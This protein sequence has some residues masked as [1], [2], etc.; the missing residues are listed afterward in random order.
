VAVEAWRSAC[1]SL[2]LTVMTAPHRLVH[3]SDADSH[4]VA[5][6]EVRRPTTADVNCTRFTTYGSE[7][8]RERER[9]FYSPY[10]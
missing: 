2:A 10:Q 4:R 8:E 9:E 1:K 3:R 7:R 6:R 5:C